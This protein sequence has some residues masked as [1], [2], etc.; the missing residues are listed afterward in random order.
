MDEKT[1]HR[2]TEVPLVLASLVYLIAY[3]WRVIGGLEGVAHVVVTAVI[4]ATW[5]LFIVDYIVRLSLAKDRRVWFR[6]HLG[7]LA[8][9][10]IPVFRLVLLLRERFGQLPS[11][12]LAED[13]LLMQLLLIERLGTP[14]KRE[15]VTY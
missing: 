11:A 10:L 5:A 4:L 14:E 8:I 15:E 7:T 9:T 13:A 6:T 12:V 3:S 1:W 2:R